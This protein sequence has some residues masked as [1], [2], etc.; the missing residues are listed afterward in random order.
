MGA[1]DG[2]NAL[3]QR[4]LIGEYK[5]YCQNAQ[6]LG[7]M[8]LNDQ[9]FREAQFYGGWEITWHP[10]IEGYTLSEGALVAAARLALDMGKDHQEARP[11][12]FSGESA[13]PDN[14]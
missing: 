2:T 6:N 13:D 4:S 8:V 12:G 3:I 11:L 9:Q 14:L 7:L 5:I 10:Q 1:Y